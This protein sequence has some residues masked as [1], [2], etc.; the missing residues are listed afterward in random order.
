[1]AAIGISVGG[2]RGIF[3]SASIGSGMILAGSAMVAASNSS[4]I[5]EFNDQ[6]NWGI[7]ASTVGGAAFGGGSAYISTKVSS[8]STNTN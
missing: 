2:A 6:G 3:S 1:M 7:V 5:D 4:S 8:T